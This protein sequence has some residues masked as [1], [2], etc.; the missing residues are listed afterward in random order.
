[1]RK[2]HP[3]R[4]RSRITELPGP[5]S[6]RLPAS[7]AGFSKIRLLSSDMMAR[8]ASHE[9]ELWENKH[10]ERIVVKRVALGME[11]TLAADV[12]GQR[13]FAR[14]GLPCPDSRLIT[15]QGQPVLV[16]EFL[17]GFHDMPDI[18]H[19]PSRCHDNPAVKR[20]LVY[21]VWL[22]HYDR[23][24]YNFMYNDKGD[25]VFIDFGGSL[26]S[27]PSGKVKGF[28]DSVT[29]QTFYRCLKAFQADRCVNEAY[30]RAVDIDM[31]TGSI[32]IRDSEFLR[33]EVAIL[34]ERFDDAF[35]D[36][37]VERNVVDMQRKNPK[38]VTAVIAEM[39][40]NLA[41]T[42]DGF[43]TKFKKRDFYFQSYHTNFQ[44]ALATFTRIRDEFDSDE[45]V[46]L[47]YALKRRRDT[48]IEFLGKL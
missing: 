10:G 42:E 11:H 2:N 45:S 40:G 44:E 30:A 43:R 15:D 32:I 26:T 19:L 8:R 20:G 41:L 27:S 1:M 25:V 16:M 36:E 24:P 38:R 5:V 17:E 12:I 39:E 6:D 28:P 48:M 35:I 23:Q 18:E 7:L 21:D 14:A 37:L 46:Y 9:V 22:H 34:K 29:E 33:K 3:D 4:H 47:R 13:V 31:K